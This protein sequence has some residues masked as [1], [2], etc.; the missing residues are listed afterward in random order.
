MD[1]GPANRTITNG[2]SYYISNACYYA[3]I[4]FTAVLAGNGKQADLARTIAPGI[5]ENSRL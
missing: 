5:Q 1:T 4:V 3:M 2:I